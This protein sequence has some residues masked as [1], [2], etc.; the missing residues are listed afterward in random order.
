MQGDKFYFCKK[1]LLG[2]QTRA[3]TISFIR[4][5]LFSLISLNGVYM[6]QTIDIDFSLFDNLPNRIFIK[7]L[8]LNYLYCN[9]H[10]AQDVGI[11]QSQII[12]KDDYEIHPEKTARLYRERD[13][14][15]IKSGEKRVYTEEYA[16]AAGNYWVK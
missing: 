8:D 4:N 15:V 13:M 14:E 3:S 6:K 7:D 12:G 1:C 5:N 16:T 10:Y 11:S 2:L 9:L